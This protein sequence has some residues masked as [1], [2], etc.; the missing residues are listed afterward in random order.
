MAER[1]LDKVVFDNCRLQ[2]ARAKLKAFMLARLKEVSAAF[3]G[4]WW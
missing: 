1:A 4:F 2:N 3:T